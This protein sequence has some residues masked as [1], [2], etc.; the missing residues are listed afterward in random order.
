MVLKFVRSVFFEYVLLVLIIYVLILIMLLMVR[1][2]FTVLVV[3]K[4]YDRV[5]CLKYIYR[6][7]EGLV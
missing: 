1:V 3:V 2:V 6:I 5:R 4:V 7:N